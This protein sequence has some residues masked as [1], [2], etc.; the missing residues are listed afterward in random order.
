L[1]SLDNW[2]YSADHTT[3]FRNTDGDWK[4]EPTITR[5]QYG[6]AQDD[7]GRLVYNSNQDQFRMDLIPSAYL[8][9]NPYY[10]QSEG[11]NVDPIGDQTTR[12]A[13]MPPAVNRG[14]SKAIL[15]PDGTLEKFPAPSPPLI[16]RGENFPAEFYG[17]A[18]VCEPAANLI[19]RNILTE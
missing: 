15:R 9:R 7:F 6:L 4:R 2:I 11:L 10:R 1:W 12:P 18:F 8:R 5:G 3:R 17:N 19:K 14:Y 16:Y 13:H